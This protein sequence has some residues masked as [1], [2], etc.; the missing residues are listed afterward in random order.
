MGV[1]RLSPSGEEGRIKR[2]SNFI[3]E[4]AEKIIQLSWQKS[5]SFQAV[6]EILRNCMCAAIM[7]SEIRKEVLKED[8]NNG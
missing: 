5:M 8:E 2:M 4:N 1:W 7:D 6:V 3:E